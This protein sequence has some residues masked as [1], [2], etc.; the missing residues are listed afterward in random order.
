[1]EIAFVEQLTAAM[2]VACLVLVYPVWVR[3]APNES[4]IA[5]SV[6]PEGA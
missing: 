5:E 6:T 4:R 1:M 2:L 3:R